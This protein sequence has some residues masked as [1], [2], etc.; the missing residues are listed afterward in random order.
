MPKQICGLYSALMHRNQNRAGFNGHRPIHVT[1]AD[2]AKALPGEGGG[3]D[4]GCPLM[5]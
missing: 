4:A 1:V 3:G 5:C 2:L